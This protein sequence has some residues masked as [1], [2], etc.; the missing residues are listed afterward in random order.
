MKKI[1]ASKNFSLGNDF[2]LKDEEIKNLD[3]TTI[4]KLNEQGFINPLSTSDLIQI[5][6]EFKT[7]EENN[8]T[9]L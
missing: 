5:E 3:L 2:Y 8:G 1:V 4:V 7:K 6:K 9:T